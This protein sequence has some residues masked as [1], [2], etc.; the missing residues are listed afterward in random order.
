MHCI[1]PFMF[2]YLHTVSPSMHAL[3]TTLHVLLPTHSITCTVYYPSCSLTY[4][5]YHLVCMHCILP[6][7]FSYLHTVSPSMHALYTT[8]H[9][10][11]PTVQLSYNSHS[12]AFVRYYTTLY[13]FTRFYTFPCACL[14]SVSTHRLR[15]RR[16]FSPDFPISIANYTRVR[17]LK[18]V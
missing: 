4:T 7:M 3:Y 11:L 10:L 8:L 17:S 9:V 12:C 2:S 1:L 18:H 5:Q 13:L 16:I 6:F 15:E 14:Y